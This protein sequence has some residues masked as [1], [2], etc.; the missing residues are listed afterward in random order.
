MKRRMSAIAV[1]LA[2]LMLFGL[3]GG[4]AASGE[5]SGGASG[6]GPMPNMAAGAGTAAYTIS[7]DGLETDDS[8][9]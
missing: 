2:V 3:C 6:G 4:A 5:A 1:M 7:K 8:L 9:A